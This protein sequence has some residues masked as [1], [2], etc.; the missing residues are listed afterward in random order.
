[1]LSIRDSETCIVQ[2]FLPK[3]YSTAITDDDMVRINSKA[4][5][6]NLVYK[7]MCETYKSYLLAIES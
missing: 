4:I 5:S 3:R 6:F 7:G 2:V 1:M